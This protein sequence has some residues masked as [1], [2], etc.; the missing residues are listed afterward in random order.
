MTPFGTGLL[1][2]AAAVLTVG[3]LAA[4]KRRDGGAEEYFLAGRG[5][6]TLVLFM[7]LFGTNATPFVL[8]GV[9]G[10]AYR[11]GLGIFSLNAPIVALGIPLSFWAIGA[12][13]RRRARELGALTPAEL[14]SRALG[15]PWVG[16]LLVLFFT[17]YTLPY[18]VT[19]IRGAA[20]ALEIGS[21]GTLDSR[22][23]AIGVLAL[24]VLYTSLGGMRATAWTNVLQG[25]LFLSFMVVGGVLFARGVGAEGAAETASISGAMQRLAAERPDLL[26]IGAGGLFAPKAWAS[27]GLAISLT[28]VAFPHM[29]ARLLAADSDR[30]LKRICL[31]YPGALA[32]LWVPAVCIGAW[33]ALAFPG[34]E[35]RA[36]DGIFPLMVERF[37]PPTW[38]ALGFIAVLAAVMSTLDAMLLTLGSM[39]TRD[40]LPRPA[41][42]AAAERRDVVLG[43]WLSLGFA[44]LVYLL[45]RFA[46]QSIYALASVAFSGYVCLVPTL[47]LGVR[48]RRFDARAGIGSLLVGNGVYFAALAS[49]DGLSAAMQPGWGGFLPVVWG[50][51]A[52]LAAGLLL[53][54]LGPRANAK[55]TAA[56]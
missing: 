37:L 1:I 2:Y 13:A 12:P 40:L 27:W 10:Q 51:G 14:Y 23:G 56:A 32:L 39:V 11:D 34:L 25:F 41:D 17:A 42:Q 19:S 8:M 38:Q 6:G 47:L 21:G 36:S 4:R 16:R 5:L 45:W 35:G 43:R 7:A 26:S 31:L 53:G 44:V 48:W 33:G 15:S 49:G 54:S 22:W 46:P 9:P 29:F 30:S 55:A 20:V 3:L 18:M 24:A 50:C 28:V 52:G